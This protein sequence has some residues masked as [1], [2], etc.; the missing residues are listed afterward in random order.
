M[1]K[2]F[3]RAP[4]ANLVGPAGTLF[5]FGRLP[6]GLSSHSLTR[7]PKLGAAQLED[8]AEDNAV[9]FYSRRHSQMEQSMR[10]TTALLCMSLVISLVISSAR[11]QQPQDSQTVDVGPWNI[12]TTYKA[13]KFDNC[14]MTRSVAG[15]GIS[16]VRTQDG[17]VLLLD[18]PQWRLERGKAYSVRLTAGSQSVDASALAETKGVTIALADHPFN[19]KLR[20]ASALEVR[21]EG[22]TLRVPLDKSTAALD[23]LELCFEKNGRES[24]ETNPFVAPSRRP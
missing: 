21:G 8:I 14:I 24:P 11:A 15:L 19:A 18:S 20:T 22:A 10:T 7:Y 16:F 17:L 4:P 2:A 23:R 12:A 5:H 6:L 3:P 13:D 1:V 9:E